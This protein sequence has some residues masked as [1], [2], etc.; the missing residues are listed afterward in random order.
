[1]LEKIH[2][3]LTLNA[4][5]SKIARMKGRKALKAR[6]KLK[7]IEKEINAELKKHINLILKTGGIYDSIIKTQDKWS[8]D[9]Q[10]NENDI[11][12]LR[13]TLIRT[14][15]RLLEGDEKKAALAKAR[16]LEERATNQE[17]DQRE[18]DLQSEVTLMDQQLSSARKQVES[19]QEA[20]EKI[21]ETGKGKKLLAAAEADLAILIEKKEKAEEDYTAAV[22]KLADDRRQNTRKNQLKEA[23]ETER[24]H[25]AAVSSLQSTIQT[26]DSMSRE[27]LG[28]VDH[29]I[30]K[31][32]AELSKLKN[33]IDLLIADLKPG[34]L[35][36]VLA[37]KLKKSIG[38]LETKMEGKL[39]LEVTLQ[40][41]VEDLQMAA[42]AIQQMGSGEGMIEGLSTAVGGL[43]GGSI[44]AQ[45]GNAV[46]GVIGSIAS[47]GE[48]MMIEDE[49]TGEK[50]LKTPDEI[51]E[52]AMAFAESFKTG[53][54]VLPSILVE[55][56]PE[57]VIAIFQ[58]FVQAIPILIVE[59]I[60]SLAALWERMT[61]IGPREDE[62]IGDYAMR[63]LMDW[64]KWWGWD[65]FNMNSQRAGGRIKSARQGLRFTSGPF[66]A[67]IP[68]MLHPNEYVVPSTGQRPQAIDRQLGAMNGGGG[69]NINI[70][71]MMTEQSAVD[72]LVRKI[73]SRFKT[74]G[75]A[76][77][78]LFAS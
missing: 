77:S 47:L 60:K 53:L 52:E 21:K 56:M 76:K 19:S 61:T 4:N 59:L 7:D 72:S 27:F 73:E 67:N 18:T 15:A 50:R 38:D 51:R 40:P 1:M 3:L 63:K 30:Q 26:V 8:R 62:S 28:L 65:Q 48:S 41:V 43:M 20:I 70:N 14:E 58:G 25:Q 9:W 75:S 12:R 42:N 37:D 57:L 31:N 49:E 64:Q 36:A 23:T 78:S 46:S 13:A 24:T 39:K 74:F 2:G 35:D 44:G 34:S 6:K 22:I 5:Q 32:L 54:K 10:K 55:V 29:P 68:A 71:S 45:V 16:K 11:L 66:G 17:L 33:D 69:V